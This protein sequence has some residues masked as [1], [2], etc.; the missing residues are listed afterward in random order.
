MDR[1]EFMFSGLFGGLFG[2]AIDTA[3]MLLF[4]CVGVLFFLAPVLGYRSDRRGALAASMYLL[5][6]YA[7]VALIQMFIMYLQVF[8]RTSRS[9]VDPDRS[10]GHIFF[11]FAIIKLLLFV[12]SMA[13]FIGG[14]Q[15]LRMRADRDMNERPRD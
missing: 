9:G 3:A 11:I 7:A 5:V 13:M 15:G 10:T 8:D 6:T 2:G 1:L 12:I 14:L 4:V